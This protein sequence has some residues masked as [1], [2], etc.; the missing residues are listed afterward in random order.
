MDANLIQI[1]RIHGLIKICIAEERADDILNQV[2]DVVWVDRPRAI[3][4]QLWRII[5]SLNGHEQCVDIR[6]VHRAIHV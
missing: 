6:F 3:H 1:T 4:V 5:A 2:C